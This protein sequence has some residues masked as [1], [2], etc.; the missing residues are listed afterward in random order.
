MKLHEFNVQ[1]SKTKLAGAERL[2]NLLVYLYDEEGIE[3]R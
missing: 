1:A 2:Y 3:Y